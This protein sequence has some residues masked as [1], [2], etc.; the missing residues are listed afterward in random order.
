MN[1][2]KGFDRNQTAV[3]PQTTAV[4]CISMATVRIDFNL[5]LRLKTRLNYQ[6]QDNFGAKTLF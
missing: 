5:N 6:K 1:Y 4:F 3:F 2:I